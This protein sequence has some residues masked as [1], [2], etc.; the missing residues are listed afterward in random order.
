MS[1]FNELPQHGGRIIA[2]WRIAVKKLLGRQHDLLGC[3]APAA[4]PSHAVCNNAQH[5]AACPVMTEQLDLILLVVAVSFVD[6]GGSCD[7]ITFGHW[8]V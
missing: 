6:A 1:L 5:A 3:F 8:R 7:S 4:A 2:F